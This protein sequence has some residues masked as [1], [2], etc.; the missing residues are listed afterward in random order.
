MNFAKNTA[1]N[2]TNKIAIIIT[3]YHPLICSEIYCKYSLIYKCNEACIWPQTPNMP[4]IHS[5]NKWVWR[6]L[7][8]IYLLARRIF[9]C[10]LVFGCVKV[11]NRILYSDVKRTVTNWY[12]VIC[13]PLRVRVIRCAA[14][15]YIR[16]S[17]FVRNRGDIMKQ[18]IAIFQT[19][20]NKGLD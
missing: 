1:I 19:R 17:R 15:F 4:N 20:N 5:F 7:Q 2:L 3:T 10:T 8:N 16:C 11:W 12:G 14:Q 18:C 9:L 6:I 13:S